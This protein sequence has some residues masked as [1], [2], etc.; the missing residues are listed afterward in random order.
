MRDSSPRSRLLA[1]VAIAVLA[2]LTSGCKTTG[3][4]DTTGSI[5]TPRSET[6]QRRDADAYGERYRANPKDTDAAIR[7]AKA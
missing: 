2:A 5:A 6:D 1:C 4:G 7:Y 3:S